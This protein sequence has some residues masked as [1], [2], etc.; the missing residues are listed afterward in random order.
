MQQII[1]EGAAT[2]LKALGSGQWHRVLAAAG[3]EPEQ[4]WSMEQA[5]ASHWQLLG[6]SSTAQNVRPP[7]DGFLFGTPAPP[8]P[9]RSARDKAAVASR[10]LQAA[11]AEARGKQMRQLQHDRRLTSQ[12]SRRHIGQRHE[13]VKPFTPPQH[14]GSDRTRPTADRSAF[15][16]TIGSVYSARHGTTVRV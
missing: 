14:G 13:Y 9:C 12:R 10:R 2:V 6:P 11:Q 8:P 1:S 16:R 15:E 7:D 3:V 5:A 4:L